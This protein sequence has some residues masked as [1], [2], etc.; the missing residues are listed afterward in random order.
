MFEQ[1]MMAY[2]ICLVVAAILLPTACSRQADETSARLGQE[3]SLRL[4]QSAS[5]IGEPLKIRF[6]EVITD[7]RCPTGATCIWAGEASCLI[8]IT[9]SESTYRKVLTQPGLSSPAKTSFADYEITFDIRPYP[10]LGKEI[11]KKDY[12]LQLVI[13]KKPALSGGI[14][15]TF[16][17]IDETYSIFIT[18]KDTI[19]QVFAVQRGESNATIPSGRIV[20][21]VVSYNQPWNWHIDSEEIGMA[22]FT[23]ELC[24]GKPS[25]VEA[26]LN[27]WVDTVGRFCPW[28]ARIVKI[29][30]FR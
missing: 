16:Q 19:E 27:Y 8:E 1:K 9:N 23:I 13:N 15:V 3:F 29:E 25:Q 2:F 20:R 22:E 17:V 30:D 18:K 26:N 4:G 11:N 21:G 28:S 12:R 7:S 10:D 5:I 14:L 6:I 24:D